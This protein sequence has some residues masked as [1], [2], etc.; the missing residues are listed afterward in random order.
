VTVT[1][2]ESRSL[3][4]SR[5]LLVGKESILIRHTDLGTL[6]LRDDDFKRDIQQE[7]GIKPG[8]AAVALPDV[9]DNVRRSLRR[10]EQRPFVTKHESLCGF[11]FDVATGKRNEVAL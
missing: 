2:D 9:E 1:D 4:I 8:R 11:V 3:A 10:I 5:R 6:S 7:S